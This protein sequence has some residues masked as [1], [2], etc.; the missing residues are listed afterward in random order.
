MNVGESASAEFAVFSPASVPLGT[1]QPE[2]TLSFIDYAGVSHEETVSADVEVYRLQPTLTLSASETVEDGETVE[3]TAHLKDPDGEPIVGENVALI[4]GGEELGTFTTDS[5][6]AVSATYTATGTGTLNAEASFAG[7]ASYEPSSNSA[8]IKVTPAS[9]FP[10]WM[11]LT[12]VL[13]VLLI[14]GSA[15]YLKRGKSRREDPEQRFNHQPSGISPLL[16]SGT[17]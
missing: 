6:G 10:L 17:P 15:V 14:L 12:A 2:F 16:K 8:K 3:I 1:A 7:S 11:I 5:D 13:V 4:V 9:G